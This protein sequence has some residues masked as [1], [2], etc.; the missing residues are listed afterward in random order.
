MVLSLERVSREAAP[1]LYA[2]RHAR[3]RPQCR[4]TA[5]S[6][7]VAQVGRAASRCVVR[8]SDEAL[9]CRLAL[10]KSCKVLLRDLHHSLVLVLLFVRFVYCL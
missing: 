6:E 1:H 3:E 7:G 10:V 5:F 4:P 2:D 8:H 9:H